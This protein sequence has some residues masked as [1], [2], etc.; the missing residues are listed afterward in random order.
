MDPVDSST[1]HS[2]SHDGSRLYVR[3][4]TG[5]LYSYPVGPEHA[6]AAKSASSPHA[7]LRQNVYPAG[8]ERH[9]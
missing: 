8:H 3:F 7:Y 2:V 5:A 1:V 9:E 4:R 6:S